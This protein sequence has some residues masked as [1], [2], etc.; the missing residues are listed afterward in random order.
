MDDKETK[1]EKKKSGAKR[2]PRRSASQLARD[3][4]RISELY[5]EGWLQ[6]DIAAEVGLA[7]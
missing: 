3:R 1:D 7:T 6:A 2:K 4:R 5:L